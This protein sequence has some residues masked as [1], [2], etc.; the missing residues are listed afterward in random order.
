[1][2]G[3]GGAVVADGPALGHAATDGKVP[4]RR[5]RL[6][7][8]LGH[9]VRAV[10][11]TSRVKAVGELVV[12]VVS[13]LEDPVWVDVGRGGVGRSG[14]RHGE[15]H[16]G[17][18]GDRRTN[19]DQSSTTR[20]LARTPSATRFLHPWS[21]VKLHAVSP[22]SLPDCKTKFPYPHAGGSRSIRP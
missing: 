16:R 3:N 11:Q 1:M 4:R 12:E 17:Q 21:L 7:D 20:P 6:R 2:E 15:R 8:V 19:G 14:R 10:V 5:H 9:G 22:R 13:V 18:D